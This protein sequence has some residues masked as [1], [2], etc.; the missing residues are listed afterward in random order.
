MCVGLV[1]DGLGQ[2]AGYAFGAGTAH[3]RLAEFE[4]HRLKHTPQPNAGPS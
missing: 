2:M 4:W 3:E 1:A